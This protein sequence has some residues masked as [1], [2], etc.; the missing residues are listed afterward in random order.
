LLGDHLYYRE[1][2]GKYEQVIYKIV[3]VDE[4]VEKKAATW[5]R[6]RT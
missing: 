3:T 6:D 2:F 4:V 1:K 5:D